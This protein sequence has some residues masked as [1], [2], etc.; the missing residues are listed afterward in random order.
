[1]FDANFIRK[2]IFSAETLTENNCP[3]DI[4]EIANKLDVHDI[5]PRVMNIEGYLARNKSGDLAIRFKHGSQRERIRFTIAHE[6]GH[7][8]IAKEAGR[9]IEGMI[10][11]SNIRDDKEEQLANRLASSLLIPKKSLLKRMPPFFSWEWVVKSSQFF[12]VSQSAF[13]NRLFELDDYFVLKVSSQHHIKHDPRKNFSL[14]TSRGERVLFHEKPELLCQ[15]LLGSGEPH[16]V[17]ITV[18][19][20]V[21]SI[22]MMPAF[23]QQGD[24]KFLNYFGYVKINR[25]N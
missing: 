22:R 20:T 19:D 5:A 21:Y 11:R 23:F 3:V 1:M 8:L 13:L 7:L 14:R 17:N 4:I 12:F 24:I 10:Q 2:T 9:E 16:L 18:G 6:I 25:N 15:R